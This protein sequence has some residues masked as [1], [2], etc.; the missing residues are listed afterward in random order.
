MAEK[1][2]IEQ[3][4]HAEK[5]LIPYLRDH[6]PGIGEFRLLEVGCA[7][8]GFLDALFR[9]GIQAVGLE[10]APGRVNLAKSINPKL[11]IVTGDITDPHIG[12]SLGTGYNLI[13]MRDVIEHIPDKTAAWTNVVRLLKTGG[14][15]YISFPPRF[16]PFGGHHQNGRSLLR[17]VPYFHML[18]DAAVHFLGKR[19]GE[20]PH[21]ADNAIAN[22]RN[23][24]SIY[25][26]EKYCAVFRLRF[27]KKDLFI[28][29]PVYQ[30]RF[31]L[32]P[33]R[34]ADVPL[35]REFLTFGC[36]CLLQKL[37]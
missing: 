37:P 8:G 6:C 23:G 36:E 27:V 19:F 26:F 34:M 25:D 2:F 16:S 28:S 24:L 17:L 33:R 21:I 11:A 20:F 9:Q 7:E 13:V 15:L 22:F 14:F 35:L 5:Y 10:L 29:R 31:G 32:K 3:R 30:T 12:K 4:E 1:H 18:P